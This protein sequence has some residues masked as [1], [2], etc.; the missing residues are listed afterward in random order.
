M[1][2]ANMYQPQWWEHHTLQVTS[3]G[4]REPYCILGSEDS[5][6]TYICQHALHRLNRHI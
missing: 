1:P 3:G 2:D 5:H 6:S 4:A